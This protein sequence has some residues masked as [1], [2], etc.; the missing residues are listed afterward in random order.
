M[1]RSDDEL[2]TVELRWQ[3]LQ[4][5]ACDNCLATAKKQKIQSFIARFQKKAPEFP[6]CYH[7]A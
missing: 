2:A 7:N 5:I 1:G 6:L 4:A 3:H